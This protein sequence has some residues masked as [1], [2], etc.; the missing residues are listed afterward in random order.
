MH[1]DAII[2]R[3]LH[4]P[5]HRA[6]P[7]AMWRSHGISALPTV[8]GDCHALLRKARND[9]AIN[10]N[11]KGAFVMKKIIGLVPE[12]FAFFKETL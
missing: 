10:W 4:N 5:C 8:S 3:F 7:E 11:P 1:F 2:C 6:E 12:L 9:R